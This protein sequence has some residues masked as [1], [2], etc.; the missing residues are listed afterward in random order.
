MLLFIIWIELR[1]NQ[2][3]TAH[4]C[5]GQIDDTES[6]QSVNTHKNINAIANRRGHFEQ[7]TKAK[8]EKVF[9]MHTAIKNRLA[10]EWLR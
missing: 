4:F 3:Q 6:N 1:S 10:D 2:E 7:N 9:H 8:S 5:I